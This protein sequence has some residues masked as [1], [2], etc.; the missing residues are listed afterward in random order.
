MA[1]LL[2]LLR[3]R[4]DLEI[5]VLAT[6]VNHGIRG[7]HAQCRCQLCDGRSV[8]AR[9]GW[10][11]FVYDAVQVKGVQIPQHPS[12][13]WARGLRYGWFDRLAAQEE[14]FHRHRPYACRTRRRLCCSAWPAE[15][16]STAMAG[17]PPRRGYYVRPCLCLTRGRNRSILRG[18]WAKLCAGRDQCGGP[19]TPGTASAI[20]AIPALQYA[21][22][23]AEAAIARLC[24]QMRELDRWLAGEAAALLQSAASM[25]GGYDVAAAAPRGRARTGRGAAHPD[26]PGAR[27]GGKVHH[28]APFSPA[29]RGEGA[30]AADAGGDL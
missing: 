8:P 6:H 16:A 21:N 27:C 24:R 7:L 23:A 22:P 1:L 26:Q 5:E 2:F 11:C 14:A 18:A 29:K 10:N 13:E 9:T 3:R 12:E 30:L 15:R 17:I 4:R 19:P 25:E 20:E 28:A